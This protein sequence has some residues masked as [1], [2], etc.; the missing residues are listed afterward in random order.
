MVGT[1]LFVDVS[2]FTALTERLA[3]RGKIGAEQMGDVVSSA[4]GALLADAGRYGADLLK[5]GGD[6]ALLWLAG[7]GR[8]LEACA[9]AH[10]MIETMKSAGRVRAPGGTAWL[11]V[12]L[13]IHS[14]EYDFFLV[15]TKHRELVVTGDAWNELAALEACATAGEIAVSAA[16]ASGLPAGWTG[17]ARGGGFVLTE[18]TGALARDAAAAVRVFGEAPGDGLGRPPESAAVLFPEPTR[19]RIVDGGEEAEHRQAAIAFVGVTGVGALRRAYGPEAVADALEAIVDRA[20]AAAERHGASF[21]GTDMSPDGTKLIIL[22]GVPVAAGQDADRLVRCTHELIAP[23]SGSRAG[24]GAG[25]AGVAGGAGGAGVAVLSIRAGCHIGRV[26]VFDNHVGPGDRRIFSFTGDSA[27]L[28]ARVM[29]LAAPGEIRVTADLLDRARH[30]PAAE[31]LPPVMVKGKAEP[32]VTW[33]LGTVHDGGAQRFET[34]LMGR[35]LELAELLDVANRAAGGHGGMVHVTGVSGSGKTRLVAEASA[36]WTLATWNV[37]CE[38]YDLNAP[39]AVLGRLLRAVLGV[40]PGSDRLLAGAQL[41]SVVSD[42]APALRAWLPLLG[43]VIDAEVAPT[44]ETDALAPRFRGARRSASVVTLLDSLLESPTALIVDDIAS[45][46]AASLAIFESVAEQARR[47]SWLVALLG[48]LEA[49][50]REVDVSSD[51][52]HIE[53]ASIDPA[54]ARRLVAE[55]LRS[56]LAVAPDQLD[57]IVKRGAGN[58]LFLIELARAAR[59]RTSFEALPDSLEALL[60]T[61]VD[62]LS[63]SD[64]RVLRAAA[65][66]GS[67]IDDE[68]LS[69]MVGPE[70]PVDDDLFRR[71][72]DFVTSD[73][74]TRHFPHELVRVAA[75]EGLSY[76]RRRELHERAATAIE[77]TRPGDEAA[78][79]LS[80]HWLEA[81]RYAPAWRY[82]RIAAERAQQLYANEEAGRCYRRALRAGRHL[83]PRPHLDLAQVAEALGDVSELVANFEQARIAYRSA[84]RTFVD[85]VDR[86]RLLRKNGV[87][88]ERAG[89]YSA[90]LRSYSIG[91]RLVADARNSATG[92]GSGNTSDSANVHDRGSGTRERCE[93]ELAAAGVLLRQGRPARCASLAAKVVG[94]A[95]RISER[96]C[97]AHACYLQHISTVYLHSPDD[98]LGRRALTIFEELGDLI[99]QGNALNNLGISAY[100][101]GDWKGSLEN[102]RASRAARDRCGD[103]I[104]AATEDNNV[105]EILSDQGHLD[106]ARLLFETV[107]DTFAFA[108]Y[109][110]GV[111][112]V[113]SN[114][115]RVA[116]RAGR[117]D[118]ARA[119]LDEALATFCDIGATAYI[120]ET[121]VRILELGVAAGATWAEE[122][123]RELLLRLEV[124]PDAELLRSSVHRLLGSHLIVL[125]RREEARRELDA[126]VA[127]AEHV[128]ARYE[129]GLALARRA[130]LSGGEDMADGDV[131][132]DAERATSLLASLGVAG[133]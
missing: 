3:Q 82:A 45:A 49:S 55:A 88:H 65:V 84:R 38:T 63:A 59:S 85:G 79:L 77:S 117:L 47:R 43:E 130:Q 58:P 98:A 80:L 132:L 107:R 111:A 13:G 10:S 99:G 128:G 53:L 78:E 97:L 15:G 92:S 116:V 96:R 131:S 125:D 101:R 33:R 70:T 120:S 36:R 23:G 114:L 50:S 64:R 61:Q 76:R 71:L 28:A 90:A 113:T 104:G 8:E 105:A 4:F 40:A 51:I 46:D 20:E 106:E 19:R 22:G 9:A 24:Q 26:F 123:G 41:E 34:P 66:L 32:V 122:K 42:R 35:D 115:G 103:I 60:A 118:E 39:Y 18:M 21:H 127:L 44:P 133:G 62:E 12:S 72:G 37:R 30:G 16:T 75:Y 73:G 67:R 89:R 52:T 27:N 81:E 5:W 100:F 57:A 94:D 7:A 110:I 29:G 91:L 17:G 6:A 68:L 56:S 83:R 102:Y 87:L 126:A 48:E 93:L 74:G 86:A 2:G 112:L 31:P 109:R 129:L 25:V 121:E 14:G 95:E 1:A 124:R 69:A 108:R 54:T 11:Q 119:L